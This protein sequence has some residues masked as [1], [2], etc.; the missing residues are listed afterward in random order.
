[1]APC[2]Y[3]KDLQYSP[4]NIT[5]NTLKQLWNSKKLNDFRKNILKYKKNLR[6]CNNCPEGR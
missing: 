6:I 1:M 5:D 4:G 2:C 3:D